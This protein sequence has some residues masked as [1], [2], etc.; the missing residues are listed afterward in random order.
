MGI[1]IGHVSKGFNTNHHLF[2]GLLDR[3]VQEIKE[4]W[5]SRKSQKEGQEDQEEVRKLGE[6]QGKTDVLAQ[7]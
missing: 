4:T 7:E 2:E 1:I 5:R 6:R 3:H